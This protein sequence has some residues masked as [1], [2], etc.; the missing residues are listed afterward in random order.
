M[1]AELTQSKRSV[2]RMKNHISK[3]ML[4]LIVKVE[5]PRTSGD[6]R[7]QVQQRKMAGAATEIGMKRQA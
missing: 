6:V 4:K 2:P 1:T 3:E 5:N 7:S